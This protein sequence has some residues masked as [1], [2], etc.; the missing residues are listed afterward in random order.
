WPRIRS[1]GGGLIGRILAGGGL[2]PAAGR[3]S[4]QTIEELGLGEADVEQSRS[5]LVGLAA[6]AKIAEPLV[7][8]ARLDDDRV[9]ATVGT[10][11]DRTAGWLS[12]GIDKLV[13]ERR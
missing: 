13:A 12:S 10:L 11:L 4:W 2:A 8:R 3:G 1:A 7:G 9:Q 6:R 5:I